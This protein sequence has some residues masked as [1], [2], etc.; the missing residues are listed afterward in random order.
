MDVKIKKKDLFLKHP[1]RMAITGNMGAGKISSC[2]YFI[3][4]N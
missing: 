1:F 3:I 2:H 4:N